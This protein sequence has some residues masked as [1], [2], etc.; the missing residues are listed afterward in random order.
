VF[1]ITVENP[2]AGRRKRSHPSPHRSRPY[3]T[4]I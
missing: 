4:I 2:G 1:H 3:M